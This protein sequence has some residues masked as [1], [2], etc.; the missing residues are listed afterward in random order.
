MA[1]LS[2]A[3]TPQAINQGR[4]WLTSLL[5]YTGQY[6]RTLDLLNN[7]IEEAFARSD[8]ATAALTLVSKGSMLGAG[9]G[10]SEHANASLEQALIFRERTDVPYLKVALAVLA[11]HSNRPA[12][13]FELLEQNQNPFAAT[14]ALSITGQCDQAAP[15]V[16]AIKKIE[17]APVWALLWSFY[18]L[19][20]CRFDEGNFISAEPY[21]EASHKRPRR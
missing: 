4:L 15:M 14:V 8:T 10:N 2:Q 16:E 12:L 6:K 21:A 1:Y 20:A 11:A 19:A 17:G 7:S 3:T 9:L 18:H 5:P 13:A